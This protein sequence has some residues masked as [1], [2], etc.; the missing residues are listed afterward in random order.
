[1]H[2]LYIEHKVVV[3]YYK[4]KKKKPN[5]LNSKANL[6]LKVSHV[7]KPNLLSLKTILSLKD[8][9]ALLCLDSL[10]IGFKV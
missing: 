3:L 9:F 1:M 2:T 8:N 5:P 10:Y 7:L 4:K 6:A